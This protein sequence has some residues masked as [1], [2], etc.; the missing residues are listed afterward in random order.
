MAGAEEMYIPAGVGRH[1]ELELTYETGEVEKLGLDIVPDS[2]ADFE[3]GFLGETTSL[4][5]AVNGHAAGEAL[6]YGVGDIVSVHILSVAAQHSGQPKNMDAKRQET[7]QSA[8][9]QV[10]NTNA[11]IFAS[12][13]N[14]KWGDYDPSGLQQDE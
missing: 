8:V 6:T 10:Q 1:V 5:Q 14:G 7:I 12:S 13:F 3:N 11:I 2:A 9:R 4:A